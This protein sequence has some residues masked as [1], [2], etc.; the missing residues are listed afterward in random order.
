[1]NVFSPPKQ[2][3]SHSIRPRS[4]QRRGPMEHNRCAWS[5]SQQTDRWNEV[6]P[7]NRFLCSSYPS[8]TEHEAR[9][10]LVRLAV[11]L[12]DLKEGALFSKDS[13]CVDGIVLGG[14][15]QW[16]PPP[17]TASVVA[18][19]YAASMSSRP[20]KS[21]AAMRLAGTRRA[22][23]ARRTSPFVKSA[24]HGRTALES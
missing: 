19:P 13:H 11:T 18:F 3:R 14:G 23:M 2:E 24:N 20:R 9:H 8:R 4:R 16:G 15:A 17:N 1:M 6:S 10:V 7:K 5:H 12:G 21:A 22:S